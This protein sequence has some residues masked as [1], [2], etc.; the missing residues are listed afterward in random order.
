M[1]G[2]DPEVPARQ[3]SLDASSPLPGC[4]SAVGVGVDSARAMRMGSA[5][6]G[7]TAPAAG[8]TA[9]TRREKTSR[10]RRRSGGGDG[11]SDNEAV[12]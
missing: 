6:T 10:R 12:R 3:E 5:T 11:G 4:H 8:A 2:R 7:D 1:E 9:E